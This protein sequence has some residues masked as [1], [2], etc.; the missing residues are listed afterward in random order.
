MDENY[1]DKFITTIALIALFVLSFFV[2]QK[3]LLSIFFGIILAFILYPVYKL[4][5]R[6][7]NSPN[8]SS[9]L[10]CT[11]LL[12]LIAVP[13][14][15]LTP[16]LLNQTF[17]LY[18]ASQNL[19]I[20]TP[21]KKVFPSLLSSSQFSSEIISLTH[22]LITKSANSLVNWASDILT[23]FLN[24]SLQFL[25]VLFTLF[26]FLRD[27]EKFTD[28]IKG[29]LPFSKDI[30][31]KFFTQTN[32]ITTAILYG[33]VVIGLIQGLIVGLGFFIF[34]VP[35]ALVLTI[36]ACIAGVLP[37]LGTT[38]VWLPVAI[39]FV[40]QGSIFGG[41]GITFFGL[42]SN[43]VETFARPIW[44][45][46]KTSIHPAVILIGMIGGIFIFGFLGFIL[47]PLILAYL[48]IILDLYRSKNK[49][50]VHLE[51]K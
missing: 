48:F 50:G 3:I 26:Y 33:Q 41:V 35:N 11:A 10:I 6:R 12:I 47:G 27:R 8:I 40:L 5:N 14:W 15:F 13:I 1:F 2:L 18:V 28:Y 42:F 30:E 49:E 9:L 32:E 36:F 46:K 31:K 29:L 22:T 37:I 16:I 21:L 23:D 19:D 7:V 34:G 4:I 43:L 25:I 20:A 24:I 38:V 44:V 51:A 39:Y 17:D 45:S